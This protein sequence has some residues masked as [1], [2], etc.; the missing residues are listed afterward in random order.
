[1][2]E[3]LFVK[4]KLLGGMLLL[5]KEKNIINLEIIRLGSIRSASIRLASISVYKFAR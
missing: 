3:N 1:M 5:L 4:E 2:E